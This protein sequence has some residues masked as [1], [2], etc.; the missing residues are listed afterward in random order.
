MFFEMLDPRLGQVV[1]TTTI[2]GFLG[3][4]QVA[5]IWRYVDWPTFHPVREPC[6]GDFLS[7]RSV[8][9]SQLQNGI[10]QIYLYYLVVYKIFVDF[11]TVPPEGF[12]PQTS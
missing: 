1:T 11:Y 7:A 2:V 6:I 12:Y 10:N 4:Q 5:K 9:V 3:A 8:G